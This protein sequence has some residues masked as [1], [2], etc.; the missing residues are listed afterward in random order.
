MPTFPKSI[1]IS[2]DLLLDPDW[3]GEQFSRPM[4]KIDLILLAEDGK[5]TASYGEL[6]KRWKWSVTRVMRFIDELEVEGFA[7]RFVGEFHGRK[8]KH[9]IHIISGDYVHTGNDSET[10]HETFLKNSPLSPQVSP[11]VPPTPPSSPL[12]PPLYPPQE[13]SGTL[14]NAH[15]HTGTHAD[16]LGASA[17]SAGVMGAGGADAG[18]PAL[19]PA[20][21]PNPFILSSVERSVAN[22]DPEKIVYFKRQHLAR[23]LAAVAAQF[24]MDASTQEKFLDHWCSPWRR[25]PSIIRAEVDEF[26]NL[27]VR[28][29]SW[30]EKEHL[31]T[32]AQPPSAESRQPSRLEQ[33]AGNSMKANQIL[34]NLY[35]NGTYKNG[36]GAGAADYPDVR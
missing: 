6:A 7:K 29:R 5:V 25:N 20:P 1:V 34:T 13:N 26:F 9:I 12:S 15:T 2:K 18:V 30:M 21:F 3:L 14:P 24:N 4:A 16:A 33:L 32:G 22:G 8:T 19:P 23:N 31:P 11:G 17:T 10:F 28:V 27:R 35:E 36:T